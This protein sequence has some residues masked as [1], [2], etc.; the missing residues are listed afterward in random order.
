[1]IYVD[2]NKWFSICE[3]WYRFLEIILQEKAITVSKIRKVDY[4]SNL[5]SYIFTF[6]KL[7]TYFTRSES[8]DFQVLL[9]RERYFFASESYSRCEKYRGAILKCTYPTIVP[10]ET[11]YFFFF[12]NFSYLFV[13]GSKVRWN[14]LNIW[15]KKISIGNTA[16]HLR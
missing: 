10:L 12:P 6:R 15:W 5:S 16:I 9:S 14:I 1:M 13:Q 7:E 4:S 11:R 8:R 3:S 2:G